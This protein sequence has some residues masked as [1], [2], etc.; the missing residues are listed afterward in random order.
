M[1]H[2]SHGTVIGGTLGALRAGLA[3]ALL[4]V[5]AHWNAGAQ[6]PPEQRSV[7]R[8]KSVNGN[9]LVSRE[10]GLATGAQAERL[11]NG[12]RIITT[13][14]SEAVIEFDN[15]CEVRLKENERFDVDST[16]ACALLVGQPLGL[17][18]AAGA[19]FANFV[20]PIGIGA[21]LLYPSNEGPPSTPVSPN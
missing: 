4:A 1:E 7:A 2:M 5:A 19:S 11:V 3:V 9:V 10:T 21:V 18:G 17:A 12:T 15:G 20:L 8:L 6:P 14:N 16:R 13:A